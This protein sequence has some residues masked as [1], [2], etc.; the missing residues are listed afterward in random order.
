MPDLHAAIADLEATGRHRFNE[1]RNAA[2]AFAREVEAAMGRQES[3]LELRHVGPEWTYVLID[4]SHTN[5]EAD[6][7]G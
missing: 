7:E 6:E 5:A 3:E 1:M 4:H 2:R